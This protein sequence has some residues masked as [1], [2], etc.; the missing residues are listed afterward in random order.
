MEHAGS[1]PASG[2][3]HMHIVFIAFIFLYAVVVHEVAH[4]WVA[5]RLGDPTAEQQGRL[6]LNPLPHID[7]IGSILVPAA[8]QDM[9][10]KYGGGFLFGWAKPVPVNPYAFKDVRKGMLLVSL[11][12]PLSNFAM[13][14]GIA[15]LAHSPLVAKGT[16]AWGVL[17]FGVFI[18]LLLMLFNLIPV[19]PLDGSKILTAILPRELAVR[20]ESLERYGMILFMILIV[21]GVAGLIIDYPLTYMMYLLGFG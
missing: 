2:T 7:P 17:E 6:T 15:G 13:A 20:F 21:S 18:N 14:V 11:A 9:H 10:Y 5:Y 19:P 12:G 3:R 4:G 8:L 1:S 16:M